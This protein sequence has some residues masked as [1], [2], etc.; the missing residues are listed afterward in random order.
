MEPQVLTSIAVAVTTGIIGS[1][2]TGL[3]MFLVQRHDKKKEK[4]EANDSAVSRAIL[5]L[6]HD[7]LLY[8]T[9]KF[10]ERRAITT[11]EKT[12]LNYLYKPYRE[13]GGNGD[14]ETGYDECMKLRIITDDEAQQLDREIKRKEYGIPD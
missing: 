7:K 8:L 3:L 14:C 1:G 4:E 2:G 9:A 10:I 5:G 6:E 11:K 13:L 12:N